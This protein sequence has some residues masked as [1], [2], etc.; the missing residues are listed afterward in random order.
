MTIN[1]KQLDGFKVTIQKIIDKYL[2]EESRF[3]VK[4][5][6][7]EQIYYV[8]SVLSEKDEKKREKIRKE[9]EKKSREANK[10]LKEDYLQILSLKEKYNNIFKSANDL[11]W[12]KEDIDADID[13]L[14]KIEN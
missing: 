4:D 1:E 9:L 2:P 7:A 6:N 14:K 11:S 5:M 13:L 3:S 8:A 12:L 10:T